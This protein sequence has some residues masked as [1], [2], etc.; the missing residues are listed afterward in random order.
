MD[1]TDDPTHGQ[2]QLSFFNRHYDYWRYSA[3]KRDRKRRVLTKALVTLTPNG[4]V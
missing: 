1:P 2:R 3:K 4:V